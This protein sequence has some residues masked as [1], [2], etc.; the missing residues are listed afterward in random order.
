M[1]RRKW[2][3]WGYEEDGV[4]EG[5]FGAMLRAVERVL[6][7][8][9]LHPL[10]VP[11]VDHVDLRPPRFPLP[12]ALA[13]FVTDEP[14][15]RVA[16]AYGKA[17]IDLVRALRGDVS[18]PPDYVAYPRTEHEISS[19]MRF[20]ESESVAITPYG[21]GTSVVGGVEPTS[22]TRFR[23]TMTVDLRQL[24]RLLEIDRASRLVHVE[25]GVLGPALE[26]GLR[27]HG[28]TL[29]HFPQSFEFSSVGG[30][31]A[32]RAAG[33]Y[34]TGP[35]HIDD[36]VAGVRMVSPRGVIEAAPRG[37]AG[38]GP[39]PERLI[40]GSEGVL[41]LITAAWLRLHAIPSHRASTTVRFEDPA[42]GIEAVRA[43]V[44]SGLQPANCRLVSPLESALTG[45]GDGRT[46]DLFLGFESADHGV[47]S[48]LD[49][50]L[51]ICAEH[52]GARDAPDV[53][54]G[55]ARGGADRWRSWFLQ[56]P[57]LRDRLALRGLVVETF[58][59]ASTWAAFNGLHR[60]LLHAVSAAIDGECGRGIVTW[61][62]THVYPDGAAPYYTVVAASEP[63][64]EIDQWVAIKRAASDA[65]EAHGGTTTHHHAV[66]RVH[67]PWYERERGSLFLEAMASAKQTL[68]P[69][70]IMNPGVLLP[71]ASTRPT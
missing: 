24:D 70:G 8:P 32:T 27:P 5:A 49:R 39:A 7:D 60:D 16:H 15:D 9:A 13:D 33:H 36:L 63:G 71:E 3:G 1:R 34:A 48:L 57:Y 37:Y 14:L 53:L 56:A 54:A 30:W 67:L 59:T 68:D 28:L 61:R 47:D 35:T 69:H 22:S 52:G 51:E 20:C 6:G 62:L 43:V 31:I 2:W 65:I 25:A 44:Q 58:E 46:A 29:R 11:L 12:A 21:G 66:G 42:A 4:D 55:E 26:A 41:G 64:R 38:G 17:Y 23:G 10:A 40:L 18:N 19:L 45:L 50:G